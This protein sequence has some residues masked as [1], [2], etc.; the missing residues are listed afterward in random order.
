MPIAYGPSSLL[1]QLIWES[2]NFASGGGTTSLAWNVQNL[3]AAEG[4]RVAG[5]ISQAWTDR[6]RALTDSDL[7]LVSVRWETQNFSGEVAKNQ[8]GGL[9]L[10]GTPPN[11]AILASYASVRKGSRGR[12][13]NY[14]PGILPEAAVDERGVITPTNVTAFGVA[15]TAFFDQVEADPA[16]INHAIAQTDTPGQATPPLLPWPAVVSRVVQPIAA[17]QRRRMRR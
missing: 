15:L 1:T 2:A 9:N 13:R 17:T 12:G 7:T 10:T 11:T 8:A 5:L 6:L 3:T 4:E 14:W 16:G